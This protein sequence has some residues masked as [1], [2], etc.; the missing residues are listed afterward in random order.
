TLES[1]LRG[2]GT[3]KGQFPQ[4]SSSALLEYTTDAPEQTFVL[5]DGRVQSVACPGARVRNLVAG[6]AVIVKD[7]VTVAPDAKIKVATID[8]LANGGDGYFP[9]GHDVKKI[10]VDGASEQ[11][12]VRDFIAAQKDAGAWNGGAAYQDG[13][14][15]RIVKVTAGN[16]VVPAGCS[17]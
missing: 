10:A 16:V 3:S 2:A 13:V 9:G 4:L 17:P 5:K 7:G 1:A 12:S 15:K 8:Y 6:G 14:G 11:S